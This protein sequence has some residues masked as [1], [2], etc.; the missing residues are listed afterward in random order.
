MSGFTMN[1]DCALLFRKKAV[2]P[3]YCSLPISAGCERRVAVEVVTDGGI[4]LRYSPLVWRLRPLFNA[5]GWLS[6]SRMGIVGDL[7]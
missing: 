4:E 3:V 1:R 5:G 6:L 2:D 7:L